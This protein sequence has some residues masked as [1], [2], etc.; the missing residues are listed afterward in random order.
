MNLRHFER[1]SRMAAYNSHS[2]LG[3]DVKR[4]K[5]IPA[6]AVQEICESVG[7]ARREADLISIALENSLVVVSMWGKRAPD[8]FCSCYGR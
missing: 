3:L 7:W 6:A 8:C 1:K 5:N 4:D 2:L